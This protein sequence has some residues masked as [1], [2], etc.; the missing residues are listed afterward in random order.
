MNREIK[1]SYETADMEWV[2]SPNPQVLR[3]LLEREKPES[4]Q[5]TSVVKYEPNSKFQ[6]HSHPYGEEIFVLE[7]EF[8]DEKGRYPAGTYIRN[9][10]GSSHSPFS[11]TGCVIF[12]K[13]NQFAEGDSER[14]V[15]DTN[16]TDWLQGLGGLLVMPLHQ[17]AGQNT[18]LV[19]WPAGERFQPHRHL[20]GEE[21]FVLS[22]T[23]KDE[24][25]SYPK[26]T[27]LRSPHNSQHFPFTDE[28]TVIMVK[29]GHM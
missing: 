22:G 25:G 8:A 19:K 16:S 15:I 21:I 7:G 3:K 1:L 26:G 13:L 17:H 20:G 29:V 6:P 14:V 18:A 12:V 2:P 9:P 28:E 5:V 4:G 27:W 23:F 10:P 24:N 11:E